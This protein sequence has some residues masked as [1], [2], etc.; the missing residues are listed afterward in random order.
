MGPNA[1][2][3]LAIS[4]L[5]SVAVLLAG[6][7]ASAKT[8]AECNREYAANKDAIK[9]AGQTKKAYVASCRAEGA[10]APAGAPAPEPTPTTHGY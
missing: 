2:R 6:A 3:T 9:A 8:T 1:M 10:S 5:S 4:L 7:P